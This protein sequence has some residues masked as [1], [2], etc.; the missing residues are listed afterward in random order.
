MTEKHTRCPECRTVYK[1]SVTQ[2]TVAQGMVCCAKCSHNFNALSNL[3][4]LPQIPESESPLSGSGLN[5]YDHDTAFNTHIFDEKD[6]LAIFERKIANSNIDFRTYLNN[7]NM[8]YNEPIAAFPAL[9][10]SAGQQNTIKDGLSNKVQITYYVAWALTNIALFFIFLFQLLWFNPA[11]LQRY[12]LL[13]SYFMTSCAVFNC[14]T[15]DQRYKIMSITQLNLNR[16]NQNTAEFSG[17]LINNYEK[18][19]DLP[20]L[21]ISLIDQGVIKA[22]YIK[23]SSDYLVES[24]NGITRIPT[25][26]PYKFK[27]SL[28]VSKIPFDNYKIEVIRP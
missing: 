18:S 5:T 25:N 26:S 22:S 14:V 1:V 24:L 15:L 10:L 7:L 13:N 11:L 21:K 28:N 20:L 8:I 6:V 4:K 2:L 3:V 27:F 19:L 16:I 9:N 12:P 17:V 23:S